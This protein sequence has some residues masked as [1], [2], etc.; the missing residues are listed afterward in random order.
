MYKTIL[1][2]VEGLERTA[3]A[4]KI[5]LEIGLKFATHIKGLRIIPTVQSLQSIAD[6][7]YLSY[8]IYEKIF[9]NQAEEVIK[10]KEAF[11][12]SLNVAGLQY[13]W[14][15]AEGDFL[16]NLKQHARSADLAIV[17]QGTN[18]MGDVMG[19]IPG[20]ILD[21]GIPTLAIPNEPREKTLAQNIF[22]AWN[23]GKESISAVHAA[24]PLL[25][26]AKKVT[27]LSIEEEKK[28]EIAT[29]DICANLARHDINVTG[30]TG[31]LHYDTGAKIMEICLK[32]HADMIVAGAWAHTRLAELIYGGVTKTLF[33]N[34]QIPVLFT[35]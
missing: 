25:K 4:E 15:E 11:I 18:D 17:L 2:P 24:L 16:K 27:V 22:I 35:H 6:N 23:G 20:F 13:E 21:S 7:H 8:E 9:K 29:T 34:Q 5:A 3:P 1:L 26:Q 33:N 19:D 10:E 28:D 12:K 31:D 14:I 30:M 32:N